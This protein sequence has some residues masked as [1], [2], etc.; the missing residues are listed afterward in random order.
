MECFIN[1]NPLTSS[2]EC[3]R[4]HFGVKMQILTNAMST[5][6][7]AGS[8]LFAQRGLLSLGS[9]PL[10]CVLWLRRYA[11]ICWGMEGEEDDAG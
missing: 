2:G 8:L 5:L 1:S 11:G 6:L 4:G 10:F 3:G 9:L 7:A